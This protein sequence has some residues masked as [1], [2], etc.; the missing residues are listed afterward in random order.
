MHST[1]LPP[2]DP[3]EHDESK[4]T[5]PG[6]LLPASLRWQRL[7]DAREDCLDAVRQLEATIRRYERRARRRDQAVRR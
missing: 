5:P 3:S 6:P 2:A 4:L 1:S 7:R